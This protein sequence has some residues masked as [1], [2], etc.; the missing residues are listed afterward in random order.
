V[1]TSRH[2]VCLAL[3]NCAGTGQQK[4]P[5]AFGTPGFRSEAGKARYV[6]P[7][8]AQAL[9]DALMPPTPVL[10]SRDATNARAANGANAAA[11]ARGAKPGC[12]RLCVAICMRFSYQL[13][14]KFR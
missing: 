10:P 1:Q 4:S 3:V 2:F 6:S 5:V 8:A 13:L 9:P 7:P 12:R 14:D 11:H